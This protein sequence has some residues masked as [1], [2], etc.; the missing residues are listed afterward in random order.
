MSFRVTFIQEICDLRIQ[1]K[2]ILP[3]KVLGA[4]SVFLSFI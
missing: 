2:E 1:T 4:T 3:S